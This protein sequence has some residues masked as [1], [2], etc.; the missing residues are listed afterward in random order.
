[1]R[2]TTYP[3]GADNRAYQRFLTLTG[4]FEVV[5]WDNA[6]TGRPTMITL[7]D[8]ESRDA[9]TL[10]LLDSAEDRDSHV[11][12]AF[13]AAAQVSAQGPIAGYAAATAL[14]PQLGRVSE[15]A[16]IGAARVRAGRTDVFRSA[17][18]GRRA[19]LI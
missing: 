19:D 5:G 13:T 16:Q 15:V 12:L 2:Q 4:D 3:F 8:L 17:R 9:F 11:L 6:N 14:A 10:A 1:M 18:I 7:I